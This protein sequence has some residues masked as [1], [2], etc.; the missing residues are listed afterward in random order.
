[1]LQSV[2]HVTTTLIELCWLRSDGALPPLGPKRR[3]ITGSNYWKPARKLSSDNIYDLMTCL[4]S[5]I[6]N[7]RQAII[8][9]NDRPVQR[10]AFDSIYMLYQS[11]GVDLVPRD[12]M[13]RGLTRDQ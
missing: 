7:R 3:K 4:W 13:S 10:Q 5:L 1:M 8:Q 6:V 9:I 12:I 2:S 11:T